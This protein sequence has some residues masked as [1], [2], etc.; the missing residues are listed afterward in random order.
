MGLREQLAQQQ[1]AQQQAQQQDTLAGLL[2]SIGQGMQMR[3]V[4]WDELGS[5]RK[6]QQMEQMDG[7]AFAGVT[8]HKDYEAPLLTFLQSLR[9]EIDEWLKL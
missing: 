2:G 1:M 4:T 5:L 9:N 8:P 3:G 7:L 6:A